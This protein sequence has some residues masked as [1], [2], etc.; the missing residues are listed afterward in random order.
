MS[1]VSGDLSVRQSTRSVEM[2]FM[3][4]TSQSNG[5]N[6]LLSDANSLQNKTRNMRLWTK[7]L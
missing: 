1:L 5:T 4:M 2:E 6:R 7:L 3:M